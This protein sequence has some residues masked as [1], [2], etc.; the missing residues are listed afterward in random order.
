MYEQFQDWP[1][2]L[3]A[4]NAGPSRVRS[5]LHAR[6][7][8]TWP[9]ISRQLPVE[10]QLYVPKFDAVLRRREGRALKDLPAIVALVT[11]PASG[12]M[13]NPAE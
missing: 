7:A 1:L 5:V 4:Y 12:R 13:A 9:E 11:P 6:A 3:A 8:T 2:S 10:T